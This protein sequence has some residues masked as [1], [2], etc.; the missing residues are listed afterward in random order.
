MHGVYQA[1][2]PDKARNFFLA[3]KQQD[4][5]V[6]HLSGKAVVELVAGGQ[7]YMNPAASV[8]HVEQLRPKGA[9]IEWAMYEKMPTSMSGNG[10]VKKAPHPRAAMLWIDFLLSKSGQAA[11]AKTQEIPAHP[12]G[13]CQLGLFESEPGSW[14]RG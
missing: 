13:R 10:L 8:H 5:S 3:L 9:P 6:Q 7:G 12:E 14:R 4:I 2:G 1:M 11:L